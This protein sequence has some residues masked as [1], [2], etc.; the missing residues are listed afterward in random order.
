MEIN[1]KT[2]RELEVPLQASIIAY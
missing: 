2:W 1:K